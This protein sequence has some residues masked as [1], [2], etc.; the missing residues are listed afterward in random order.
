MR[1]EADAT[2]KGTHLVVWAL[3]VIVFALG[4]VAPELHDARTFLCGLG[5]GMQVAAVFDL[6]RSKSLDR[7]S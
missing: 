6:M 1:I 2:Y 3:L 5:A 7:D 4:C